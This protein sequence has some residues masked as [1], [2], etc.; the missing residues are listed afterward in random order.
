KSKLK[1]PLLSESFWCVMIVLLFAAGS[2][3]LRNWYLT[4][5]PV[6]AFFPEIFTNSVRMNTDVLRSAELEW[7]RNGDGIGRLAEIEWDISQQEERDLSSPDYRREAGLSERI[8][9]SIPFW[10][11][12]RPTGFSAMAGEFLRPQ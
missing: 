4:G 1:T 9:A 3:N 12:F 2:W 10:I 8:V 6:Y 11:G 5:N 7:F